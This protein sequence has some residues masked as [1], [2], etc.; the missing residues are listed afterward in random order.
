[1]AKKLITPQSI[2]APIT[3]AELVRLRQ[4]RDAEKYAKTMGEKLRDSLLSRALAGAPIEQGDVPG[5]FQMEVT[6]RT[7]MNK[8]DWKGHYT[9]IAGVEKVQRLILEAGTHVEHVLNLKEVKPEM[10]VLL[11]EKERME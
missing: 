9:E 8:I 10:E 7:V 4:Y 1:M 5:S 3:Q 2:L 6:E 11:I